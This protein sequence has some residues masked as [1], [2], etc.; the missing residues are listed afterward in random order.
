[1]TQPVPFAILEALVQMGFPQEHAVEALEVSGSAERAI[2]LLSMMSGDADDVPV[3]PVARQDYEPAM[4]ALIDCY[5][6][7]TADEQRMRLR[8]L[9]P[10]VPEVVVDNLHTSCYSAADAIGTLMDRAERTQ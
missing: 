1:M 3:A 6:Q 7:L 5:D 8:E 4:Q 2:D 9:F 10:T